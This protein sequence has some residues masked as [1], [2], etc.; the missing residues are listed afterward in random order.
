MSEM[1]EHK[2]KNSVSKI[3]GLKQ[4]ISALLILVGLTPFVVFY[5]YSAEKISHLTLNTSKDRLVSLRETKKIQI[6]NYFKNIA[7]QA[8]T[9]SKNFMI[10]DAMSKFSTAFNQVEQQTP[11]IDTNMLENKLNGRYRYQQENTPGSNSGALNRWTPKG[12]TSKILQ[13]LYISENQ[14]PTGKKHLLNAASDKT[15]YS[16]THG[17]YHPPIRQFLEE[18]GYYDI[19]LVDADTG[20]I[21]YSVFK[22]VDYATNLKTG[23]YKDSG[24]GKVFN[25]AM[26]ANDPNAVIIEDFTP[27][28]PS[29][30]ASASFIASPIYDM[31]EKIGVLIFQA[32]VDKINDV[33]TSGNDWKSVGLGESGEVYLVGQDFKMRNNSRFLIESPDEYFKFLEELKVDPTSIE[34]QKVLKTSIGIS[35]VKT[36]GSI[37]SLSGKTDFQVF[38]DYRGISVLSAYAPVD[39]LGLKW[40]ILAEIDEAEAFA[41]QKEIKSTSIYI[42]SGLAVGI[43]LMA[44]LVATLFTKRIRELA[45]SMRKI[46]DGDLRSEPLKIVSRD[47]LGQLRRTYNDMSVAMQN[48]ASQADDIANNRLGKEYDLKGELAESFGNMVTALKEKQKTDTEMVRIA[49]IV[50]NNPSNMMVADIDLKVAYINPASKATLSKIEQYLPIKVDEMVGQSIDIFHKNPSLQ[51]NI[52][53]NPKNLPHRALIQL[54]PEILDLRINAN[55][56]ANGNYLG[57]LVDW[58]VATEKVKL[59]NEAKERADKEKKAADELQSKVDSMLSVVQAASNGD[60]TQEIT[61][62]G[63]SAIGQMGAGLKK[64]FS[65][66]RTDLGDISRNTESVSAAAEELTATSTTMSANAEETSAQAGVVASASED[67][68]N[69]VQTVATGAEEMSASISEI[70]NNSTQ[71]AQISNEAVEVAKRTNETISTLGESSKEIGEV[72]KVITSIAEQTNLLALNATIEAARAGEAGKGFA[73]VANEVK[74]L[75]NQT[76][77]ATEEISNKVQTIQSNTGNAVEAIGEI[78]TIIN[79]INDISSTIASAVEEQS[80]TTNEMSRNVQEAA[81]GVGEISQNISGVSTAAEETTQGSSQTKDAANELSK[82]A[83]DLQGLV[84]RF[85]I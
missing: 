49:A 69:N 71:A 54:G 27:Y 28:E 52:L 11:S 31:G 82:L 40:G 73:V 53:S 39:I 68:G 5:F 64:L 10:V 36:P 30:N 15:L 20:F 34:K 78:G 17:Q 41:V 83:V 77:K 8:N 57:P 42:G 75:A 9:Y 22:E 4:K 33:M 74:E 14:H 50:E 26:M 35:E 65:S 19:F 70:A 24:I 21:V 43:L 62:N 1:S 80:A 18:F 84:S 59:E 85:K 3:T 37:A 12:T 2:A 51:R 79:Q 13:N 58:S 7:S 56:D 47:E 46:A 61:V 29:Y 48:I 66:L 44:L 6:E 72:V 32:P 25:R 63:N 16:Q 45:T 38:P 23:P 81:R 60:L 67:V 76:A 55:I